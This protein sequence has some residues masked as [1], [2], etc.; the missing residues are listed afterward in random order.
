[1]LHDFISLIYPTVCA[2]CNASLMHHERA[3]CTHC[4]FTLPQTGYHKEEENPI[5]KLFWGRVEVSHAAAYYF[6]EKKSRVQHMIHDLKYN[7]NTAVGFEMGQLF[8]AELAGNEW[9]K[10]VDLIVPVPLH[11]DKFA[12]RGFNQCDFIADG[13]AYGMKVRS[14]KKML[15][16]AMY[17]ES[18]TKKNHYERWLNVAEVFEAGNTGIEN[19]RHILLVDDVVTTGSTLVACANALKENYSGKLSIVT[20]ACAV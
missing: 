7:G 14:E 2:A 1:M 12:S 10:D 13:L 4:I 17:T 20:M 3:L 9:Y 8:G 19:C 11:P 15:Q 18:Q 5:I 16:R 6:F